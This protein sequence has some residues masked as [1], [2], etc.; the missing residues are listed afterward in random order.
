MNVPFSLAP[1]SSTQF[2]VVLGL[3][4]RDSPTPTSTGWSVAFGAQSDRLARGP[5]P[6]DRHGR[7]LLPGRRLGLLRQRHRLLRP[8][9][10]GPATPRGRFCPPQFDDPALGCHVGW[11]LHRD[12]SVRAGVPASTVTSTPGGSTTPSTG[13]V[14]LGQDGLGQRIV[15]VGVP[16]R[17]L[18]G[19]RRRE[20]HERIADLLVRPIGPVVES[21]T[22]VWNGP[23][24]WTLE[25]MIH[26]DPLGD[27][28]LAGPRRPVVRRERDVQHHRPI[29]GKLH[30]RR[31]RTSTR[32]FR[33]TPATW[34]P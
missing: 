7:D 1:A 23:T 4:N 14:P 29:D 34:A 9:G 17:W 24:T 12:S 22:F 32:T 13:W 11:A 18:G 6:G 21:A 16:L 26:R 8:V 10:P 2:G 30:A 15:I 25:V 28:V 5:G 20:R 33:S 19:R 27:L 3:R 31:S